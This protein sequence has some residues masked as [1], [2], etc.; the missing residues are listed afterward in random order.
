M[1]PNSGNN[2]PNS[3]IAEIRRRGTPRRP[4]RNPHPDEHHQHGRATH[5][6]YLRHF[7]ICIV[8]MGSKL[9]SARRVTYQD[10]AYAAV[11]LFYFGVF[12]LNIQTNLPP[13]TDFSSLI[14]H[15]YSACYTASQELH[16]NTD[17]RRCRSI[18]GELTRAVMILNANF[19][20]MVLSYDP[21]FQYV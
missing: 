18:L 6:Q 8:F 12:H 5:S 1:P 7:H 9:H 10:E 3:Q 2:L 20:D 13:N 14:D 15:F 17:A 11:N 19:R 21:T 4:I 16:F